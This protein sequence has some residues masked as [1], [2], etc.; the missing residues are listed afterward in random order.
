M[1]KRQNSVFLFAICMLFF[2]FFVSSCKKNCG[3]TEKKEL[4]IELK[5][6]VIEVNVGTSIDFSQY[7]IVK[8]GETTL[9]FDDNWVELSVGNP[10]V[11]GKCTY[12]ISVSYDGKNSS[13]QLTVTFIENPLQSLQIV[14]SSEPVRVPVGDTSFNV[15]DYFTVLYGSEELSKLSAN[16]VQKSGNIATIGTMVYEI[17]YTYLG[18]TRQAI[19]NVEVYRTTNPLLDALDAALAQIYDQFTYTT[20]F[21]S[22]DGVVIV[23]IETKDGEKNHIVY[24]YQDA[25]TTDG[26]EIY[27]NKDDKY[28]YIYTQ[29]QSNGQWRNLPITHAAW[30]ATDSNGDLYYANYYPTI[31]SPSELGLVIDDFEVVDGKI[32]CKT[33]SLNIVGKKLVDIASDTDEFTQIAISL[34]ETGHI[35]KI[36]ITYEGE[37][38]YGAYAITYVISYSAYHTASIT[39]PEADPEFAKVPEH[40]DPSI[41]QTLTIEEQTLFQQYLDQTYT[42]Y[43]FDYFHTEDEGKYIEYEHAFVSNTLYKILYGYDYQQGYQTNEFGYY[44]HIDENK[45]HWVFEE[46]VI[47]KTL[48]KRELTTQSEVNSLAPYAML[49][50]NLGLKSEWFGFASG[51][52]VVLT[53]YLEQVANILLS[54]PTDTLV[55]FE[56]SLNQQHQIDG[57]YYLVY[58]DEEYGGFYYEM[59][60]S[61]TNLNATEVE[62]PVEGVST[63]TYMSNEQQSILT[64]AFRKD[65]SNVTVNDELYGT[66]F[67]FMGNTIQAY[68]RTE[69]ELVVDTYKIKDGQYY[70]VTTEGEIAIPYKG[71]YDETIEEG[72]GFTYFV[73]DADFS[74]IDISKVK[75]NNLTGYFYI[76]A[77]DVN[78]SNFLFYYDYGYTFTFFEFLVN[79]T[80]FLEEIRVGIQ[81]EDEVIYYKLVSYSNYGTTR[82]S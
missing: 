31:Q 33:Q 46:D 27:L 41:A 14:L 18:I 17:S 75:Y 44:Y 50:A 35:E 54:S 63:L 79:E 43:E 58:S 39:L 81:Y 80:G 9:D 56:V 21:T 52:Y 60:Y 32:V 76:E 69:T 6:E 8:Y 73:A 22:D 5:Q 16:V 68:V 61:Y 19:L 70:E 66:V 72:E 3:K 78:L 7:V 26:F 62:M 53:D 42:S 34:S 13:K 74:S 51:K 64:N 82:V 28:V 38:E 55:A 20:T 12:T 45:R 23:N 36:E 15:L 57:F 65:F 10:A 77:S 24:S 48:S 1:L 2:A 49:I 30:A 4:T 29:D 40:I 67:Y 47:T 59:N 37:D 71:S 25:T 11:V